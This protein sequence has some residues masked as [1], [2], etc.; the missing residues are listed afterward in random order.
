MKFLILMIVMVL[1]IIANAEC[2]VNGYYKANG[3]WVDGY[4]K[5]GECWNGEI[6]GYDAQ[7]R[8]AKEREAIQVKENRVFIPFIVLLIILLAM[9]G[10]KVDEDSIS[11]T[12]IHIILF[13]TILSLVFYGFADPIIFLLIVPGVFFWNWMMKR[14]EEKDKRRRDEANK[15]YKDAMEKK[16]AIYDKVIT[17]CKTHL[18]KWVKYDFIAASEYIIRNEGSKI[19]I[20]RELAIELYRT[21]QKEQLFNN[22][23]YTV[24]T[25]MNLGVIIK[26]VNNTAVDCFLVSEKVALAHRNTNRLDD[27]FT[28][29][30]DYFTE[31][32]DLFG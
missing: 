30:D 3:S 19:T 8:T 1:A 26:K 9:W 17:Y 5:S 32:D 31:E 10:E 2:E 22:K 28:K 24:F 25:I 29:K 15:K 20:S 14:K 7:G 6:I 11:H 23:D 13:L 18:S 12:Y 4:T 16:L 21:K 27:Y